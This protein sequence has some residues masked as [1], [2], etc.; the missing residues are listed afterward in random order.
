MVVGNKVD[1]EDRKV[2]DSQFKYPG[3]QNLQFYGMNVEA[4]YQVKEPFLWMTRHYF[5]DQTVEYKNNA[6]SQDVASADQE[7]GEP[8]SCSARVGFRSMCCSLI[9]SYVSLFSSRHR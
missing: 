2:Q 8:I 7:N 9:L 4:N 1:I 6:A 5:G 3:K